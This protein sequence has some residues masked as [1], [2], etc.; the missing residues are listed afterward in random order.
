MVVLDSWDRM[1]K[2]NLGCKQWMDLRAW[3]KIQV[4]DFVLLLCMFLFIV[5]FCVDSTIV[6]GNLN[7][8]SEYFSAFLM[9]CIMLLTIN[10]WV[11]HYSM[12]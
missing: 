9:D 5:S 7:L 10:I 11:E 12:Y 1:D 8:K 4:L 3:V 6:W 2:G